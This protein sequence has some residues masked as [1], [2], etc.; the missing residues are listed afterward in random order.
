MN[1]HR[2]TDFRVAHV[3]LLDQPLTDSVA[4]LL[5]QGLVSWTRVAQ[6]GLKVRASA[7]VSSFRHRT[8]LA[9]CREQA[10]AQVAALQTA[11]DEESADL[12]QRQQ[13]ARE[14]AAHER[15]QRVEKALHE[16]EQLAQRRHEV[17]RSKGVK[18]REARAL[19]T[20]PEAPTMKMGDGGFRPAYNA[21]FATTTGGGVIVGVAVT[22]SGR[23]SGQMP[24]MIEQLQTR[25]GR[26]PAEMLTDGAFARVDD[27]QTVPEK[28][29]VKLLAPVQ[30]EQ[31]KRAR[32]G[33]PFMPRPRDPVG[34]R[35]RL[36]VLAVLLWQ[37]LAHHLLRAV[38]LRKAAG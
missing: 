17:E 5:Q 12:S 15:Q 14:R 26:V 4:T 6:D 11:R 21:Q 19:T 32:G 34:V 27:I 28:Q 24:P 30:N 36:K 20:D 1:Y 23:D 25:Y 13:A 22:S 3:E 18:A 7:G 8:T 38:A 29:G 9:K 31:K 16:A 37:A 10:Q 2:L 33:D 35:G